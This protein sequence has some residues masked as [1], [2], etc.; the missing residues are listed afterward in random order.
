MTSDETRLQ[1]LKQVEAGI[2]SP[3][4][5]AGLLEILD[6]NG[7]APEPQ[8]SVPSVEVSA[9]PKI[10]PPRVAWYWKLGWSL[11][12]WLGMGLTILSAY[13]MYQGYL[14]AGIGIGFIF[15]WI[16][17]LLGILLIYAGARLLE[18]PWVHLR[19][20]QK[21][22]VHPARIDLAIPLPLGF[23]R[24]IINTFDRFMP[25][26]V[27][28]KKVDEFLAELEQSIRNGEPFQVQVDDEKDGDHVEVQIA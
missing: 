16:P 23:I 6:R 26:E 25:E 4:E 11:F 5:G 12:L 22:A 10:E 3:E 21:K 7:S 14:Q 17:F 2:L 27:R 18:A 15:S 20:R 24:W 28:G 13:W 19:V 9:L 8:P 1:I